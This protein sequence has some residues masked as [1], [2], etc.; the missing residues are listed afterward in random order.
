MRT[1]LNFDIIKIMNTVK[2]SRVAEKKIKQGI[3]V[4]DGADFTGLEWTDTEVNLISDEEAF[5]EQPIFPN[6]I[7]V[8]DGW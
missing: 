1:D 5:L 6:K 7:R 8:L 2:V 4:L 3:C